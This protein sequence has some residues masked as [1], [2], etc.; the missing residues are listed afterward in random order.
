MRGQNPFQGAEP[1]AVAIRAI[2]AGEAVED[3]CLTCGDYSACPAVNGAPATSWWG[4]CNN[5]QRNNALGVGPKR[6]VAP[7]GTGSEDTR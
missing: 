4:L 6:D 5:Y 3:A 2:V 1:K 7:N